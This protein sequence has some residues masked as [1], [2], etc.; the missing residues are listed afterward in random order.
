MK[1]VFNLFCVS[2]LDGGTTD[3]TYLWNDSKICWHLIAPPYTPDFLGKVG[4]NTALGLVTSCSSCSL[5]TPVKAIRVG[6]GL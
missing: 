6:V 5:V 1:S 2:N 3:N 4:L